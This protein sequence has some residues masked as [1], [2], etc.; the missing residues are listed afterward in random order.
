MSDG[1]DYPAKIADLLEQLATRVRAM[2]VDR[3]SKAVNW[4]A[5]GIILLAISALAVFWLFI[6]LFRALGELVGVEASYVIVGGI[7]VIVG[8]FLWSRR[9]PKDTDTGGSDSG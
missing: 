8:V 6:G 4:T 3:V 9:Y 7:L 5:V 1:P 2:T